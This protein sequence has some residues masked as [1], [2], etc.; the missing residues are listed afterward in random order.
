MSPTTRWMTRA[1]ILM[2]LSLASMGRTA[3]QTTG[4]DRLGGMLA[5]FSRPYILHV[6]PGYDGRVRLPLVIV[7]HGGGGNKEAARLQTCPNQDLADPGCLDRLADA[8]GFFVVYPDG[9]FGSPLARNFRVFNAGGGILGYA[10]IEDVACEQGVDDVG[11]VSDLIDDVER[12]VRVDPAR[13][14]ATGL[15]NGGALCYRLACQLSGRIA[16]I[17]PIAAGNQF[18]AVESCAPVR[19]V[20]V[21]D[22]HGTADPC[23]PYD[24]GSTTCTGLPSPG[25]RVSVVASVLGWAIRNGCRAGVTMRDWPDADPSDGTTV[26]QHTFGDCRDGGDVVHLRVNGGGHTWPGGSDPLP[27]WIVGTSS[28]EFSANR[29]MWEFFKAHPMR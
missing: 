24:G 12:S 29:V 2:L 7:F 25:L 13:I 17:A 11:Y 9:T 23:W 28:R 5:W 15:S 10:C 27:D 16:A 4:T 26:T 1:P 20:P 21:L 19:S 8:E 22:I 6:P 14:Y 18:A 3:A